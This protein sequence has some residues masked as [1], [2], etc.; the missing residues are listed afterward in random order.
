MILIMVAKMAKMWRC[1]LFR[2]TCF[3]INASGNY[4]LVHTLLLYDDCDA[5]VQTICIKQVI[6]F[7]C[8]MYYL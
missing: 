8:V 3:R 5:E 2:W 7:T 4:N 1:W 6:F